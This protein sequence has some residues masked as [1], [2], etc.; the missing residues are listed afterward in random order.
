MPVGSKVLVLFL[1]KEPYAV[2]ESGEKMVE[3]R[4]NNRYWRGRIVGKGITHVEFRSGYNPGRP[5][6]TRRLASLAVVPAVDKC[7]SNGLHV[8]GKNFLALHLAPV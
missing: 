2:M 1:E 3:Y 4:A 5:R 6:F 7:Y 8:C